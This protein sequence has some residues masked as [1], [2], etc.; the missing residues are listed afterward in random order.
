MDIK[1]CITNIRPNLRPEGTS[2]KFGNATKLEFQPTNDCFVRSTNLIRQITEKQRIEKLY[3]ETYGEVLNVMGK[4]NPIINSL[5][6]SKP[7][8]L[9]EKY[10][11][12]DKGG[13]YS[14]TENS[15][16]I[17]E[18]VF[19]NS[20]YV[21]GT[22]D[23]IGKLE[24]YIGMSSEKDKQKKLLEAQQQNEHAILIKLTQEEQ[25]IYVKATLA[26]EIRH[27]IQSH[28][29][30]STADCGEKQKAAISK[31]LK[32]ATDELKKLKEEYIK[33]CEEAGIEPSKD[34][35]NERPQYY[36]I[37]QPKTILPQDT[38]LKFSLFA[39]DNRYWSVNDHLFN[40]QLANCDGKGVVD[41]DNNYYGNALEIDAYNFQKEFL[42]TF[43]ND[44]QNTRKE[45][46]LA[47]SIEAAT[48]TEKGIDLL[49]KSGKDFIR[50]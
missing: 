38:K 13:G 44:K 32:P 6:L 2:C 28:L 9:I 22:L 43:A 35:K 19:D 45:I 25:D 11:Q 23:E 3:N 48:A 49:Q 26:H 40:S 31:V 15:I 46:I 50:G 24:R 42:Y 5:N 30:A 41:F 27:F 8:L 12:S 47:F 17:S 21:I 34:I 10:E 37:Y 36:E 1:N 33:L 39:D 16:G 29:I 18:K 4:T 14:F 20:T 7:E